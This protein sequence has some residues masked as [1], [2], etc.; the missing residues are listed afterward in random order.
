MNR[1]WLA[2]L[3]LMACVVA[4]GAWAQ[5]NYGPGV[6]DTEIKIGQTMPYSGP[7]S[8]Y[9]TIGTAE[10]AY[11]RMIND[12][13]G[14]NGRKIALISLDDGY[15]PPKTVE[16]TR[17]LVED[18]QVLLVFSTFGTATNTAV[19]RYLNDHG[20]PQLF[21]VSGATRWGDPRHFPW[22]MGFQPTLKTEGRI[23]ARYI[24]QH[25]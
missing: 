23:V 2:G 25:R 6:S 4:S 3:S 1:K 5:K 10:A 11:F 22:T 24:L 18:A 21:P 19:Q 20:V 15:T 16:L 13:G 17:K 7:A 9:G 14:I 12:Q 8:I